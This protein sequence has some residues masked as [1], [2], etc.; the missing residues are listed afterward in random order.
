MLQAMVGYDNRGEN[1]LKNI[2]LS[3]KMYLNYNIFKTI[4]TR[5]YIIL[6]LII[7]K[8][9]LTSACDIYFKK[10]TLLNAKIA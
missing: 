9:C 1:K 8:I 5:E 6:S 10:R 7:K 3:S 2:C 4:L